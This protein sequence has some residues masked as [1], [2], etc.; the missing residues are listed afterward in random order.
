M[1]QEWTG[2]P[3]LPLIHNYLVD[4][5]QARPGRHDSGFILGLK[6]NFKKINETNLI[7]S[8]KNNQSL[9]PAL[10]PPVGCSSSETSGRV[11]G[12]WNCDRAVSC[13]FP[14]S[15]ANHPIRRHP[16]MDR[17]LVTGQGP[18]T[19]SGTFGQS[20]LLY[21]ET[22]KLNVSMVIGMI[23]MHNQ[24]PITPLP[25]YFWSG[26]CVD[27][28]IVYVCQLVS[29]SFLYHTWEVKAP[30]VWSDRIGHGRSH[31]PIT[32]KRRWKDQGDGRIGIDRRIRM[33]Q[34]WSWKSRPWNPRIPLRQLASPKTSYQTLPHIGGISTTCHM[35]P[36]L[37]NH[38]N[39]HRTASDWSKWAGGFWVGKSSIL[40]P[41]L[42]FPITFHQFPHGNFI[43][44][45]E[46]TMISSLSY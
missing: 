27:V 45:M 29:F 32:R 14:R 18:R 10:A 19:D 44:M 8:L 40:I 12:N 34:W 13:C 5:W 7:I 15:Q 22:I 33:T 26:I 4:L 21:Y 23:V 1:I 17:G 25:L 38:D 20:M 43:M 24:I 9:I 39:A 6:R 46:P 36:Q 37:F 31:V 2:I 16:G 30:S 3:V 41:S 35:Q 42:S 28:M 11:P